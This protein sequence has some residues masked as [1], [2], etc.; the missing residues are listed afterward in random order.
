M[1]KKNKTAIFILSPVAAAALAVVVAFAALWYVDNRRP[2]F[3]REFVLFVY[4][5]TEV[6]RIID[7][8]CIDGGAKSRASLDRCFRKIGVESKLKPGRYPVRTDYPPVYVA[9]MLAFGW[10]EPCS[11]TLSGTLRQKGRI[12]RVISSQMMVD[13]TSV[14]NALN[15]GVF[16]S[17]YGFT[18][19]NVFALIIPDT[20]QMYWT[21]DVRE[22][23]DRFKKEYDAFWTAERLNAA[24]MQGLTPMEVSVVASIVSG[25]T[26]KDFE[27]P[28]I[29]GV[30]LNRLRKGMKLQ[31]DPTVCYCYDY[32]LNRVLKRHLQI[33]S[34]YNT[35]KYAGLPPAPINVPSKAC[36]EAVLHP[37]TRNYLFF[38]AD[39]SFNGTHRFAATYSEHQR[40]AREF[41]RALTAR[42][43]AKAA[44][45][46]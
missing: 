11:L 37:D 14:M 17:E 36:L 44:E 42:S 13:S 45:S 5:D 16:L 40:N 35:Y 4:P 31:A 29:A 18:P 15:D 6:P 19:E 20:Y 22:I 12:A 21:A 23:F 3:D 1:K 43:R 39:P 8:L 9:R 2:G 38:C 27:F 41:Q 30:Y 32:S 33:D 34:P 26:L 24:E 28:L 46:E 10:Q 7:A 25:E